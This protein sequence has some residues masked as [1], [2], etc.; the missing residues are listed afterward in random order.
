MS[1]SNDEMDTN[2]DVSGVSVKL[3]SIVGVFD[4]VYVDIKDVQL[5]VIQDDSASN[6]WVSL[7]AVNSGTYNMF[8]F[9]DDAAL[10]LVTNS[11][12]KSTYIYGI[13]LVLGDN[14]FVDIDNT[15]Y[16]L[17]ITNLGNSNP[18]N[19]MTME[20]KPNRF[21]DITIDMNVDRSLSFN[22]DENMMVLNPDLYTEIRQ[23]QY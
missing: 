5:K 3:K 12:V 4:K 22:E 7:N 20:L 19:L 11:E 1:C 10:Q 14:N 23:V 8:D 21:Y 2:V 9:R 15:L 16:S 13:R 6:A 18:S 17:D